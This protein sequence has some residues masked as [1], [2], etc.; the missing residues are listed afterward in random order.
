VRAVREI[1]VSDPVVIAFTQLLSLVQ[2]RAEAARWV[3]YSDDPSNLAKRMRR[4]TTIAA[5]ARV[6]GP[7]GARTLWYAFAA[8]ALKSGSL[9]A[10]Y[11]VVEPHEGL[12]NDA[13]RTR[14]VRKY[15][16]RDARAALWE[17]S[18]SPRWPHT[19]PRAARLVEQAW[20]T[21]IEI[22]KEAR[23]RR[24]LAFDATLPARRRRRKKPAR[25]AVF[26]IAETPA[27]TG[28]KLSGRNRKRCGARARSR[29]G[30]PCQCKVVPGRT[31]C[32]L[33]GGLS[34][35][36]RTAEGKARSA[37]GSR[38]HHQQKQAP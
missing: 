3:G 37:E 1:A 31:R 11:R 9:S 17:L 7:S 35:G 10:A 12:S 27:Q 23:H 5:L 18:N 34:T 24:M 16:R 13:V 22:E 21:Q 4:P 2:S 30:E 36:P 26:E 6:E 38:R 25:L 29:G 8:V 20:E 19:H 33:H 32:R 15:R 14:A 28:E